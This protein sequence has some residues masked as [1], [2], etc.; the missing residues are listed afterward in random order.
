[1]RGNHTGAGLIED[2]FGKF[3][4]RLLNAVDALLPERLVL[5]FEFGVLFEVS[6]DRLAG[7]AAVSCNL[8]KRILSAVEELNH[9]LL[10]NIG[11]PVRRFKHG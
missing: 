6:L 8:R 3:N 10:D 1:M 7:D 9:L 2:A 4:L 11:N 5:L